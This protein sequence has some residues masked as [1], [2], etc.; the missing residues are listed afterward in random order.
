M[1]KNKSELFYD[2]LCR[3]LE[4][5]DKHHI[6]G[7]IAISLTFFSLGIISLILVLNYCTPNLTIL[8]G[9]IKSCKN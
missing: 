9:A 8:I 7:R 1:K 3:I 2:G 5:L 6:Q 4:Y